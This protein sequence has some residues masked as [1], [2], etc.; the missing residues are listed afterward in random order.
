MIRRPP[1]STLFPYTT[2]FRSGIDSNVHG[3]NA[4]AFGNHA[5]AN[6]D[7]SLSIGKD[8][9]ANGKNSVVLGQN[10]GAN[11]EN[12]IAFGIRAFSNKKNSIVMGNEVSSKIGRASC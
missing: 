3:E 9:H 5:T 12:A 7:N 1:R 6:Q 8:T 4:I 11:E 2:L 10:S